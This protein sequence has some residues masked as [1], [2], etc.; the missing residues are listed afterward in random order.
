[1]MH[2]ERPLPNNLNAHLSEI[3]RCHAIDLGVISLPEID[4]LLQKIVPLRLN[5][6]IEDTL[7]FHSYLPSLALGARKLNPADL[8]KPLASFED[9]GIYLH[10]SVRGGGITYHWPG[11]LVGYP[12]FKLRPDEQNI[13]KFMFQ[14]E[15]VGLRVLSD[16]GVKAQRR[17]D[18]VAQ[19]GLWID[20]FKIASMGIHVSRWVTSY[21]FALNLGGDPT[22]ADHIRPCGLQGVKLITVADMTGQEPSHDDVKKIIVK[23]IS[24]VFRREVI[25]QKNDFYANQLSSTLN[26]GNV[27]KWIYKTRY[28]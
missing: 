2:Q 9:Q 16:L 28:E 17:R 4:L 6:Q 14:L 23:H 24:S 10:K 26:K 5:N 12:V 25:N 22:P 18:N 7:I 27:T 20:N 21:G 3:R 1:M 8:L 13:S 15:E 19:I 11:Q